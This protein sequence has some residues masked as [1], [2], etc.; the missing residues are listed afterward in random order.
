M[1][2]HTFERV[3][4]ENAAIAIELDVGAGATL[5]SLRN[6]LTARYYPIQ[7]RSAAKIVLSAAHRRMAI[8]YWRIRLSSPKRETDHL[9]EPGYIA[10]YFRPEVSDEDWYEVELTFGTSDNRVWGTPDCYEGYAWLRH[11]FELP[12]QAQGEVV[13]IVVGGYDQHD[14]HEY[15]IYVN[16]EFISSRKATA[17]WRQ[18]AVIELSPDEPAYAALRFGEHN[19]VA[20]QVCNLDRI[21]PD[22]LDDDRKRYLFN[23]S[24]ADQFVTIG[25]PYQVVEAFQLEGWAIEGNADDTIVRAILRSD[26]TGLVLTVIYEIRGDEPVLRKHIDVQNIGSMPQLLLDVVLLDCEIGGRTDLGGR[27]YPVYVNEEIFAAVEHPAG[28]NQGFG[29]AVRLWHCPGRTLAPGEKTPSKGLVIGVGHT[30]EGRRAFR[31]H[32]RRNGRRKP[33]P[34]AIYDVYGLYDYG[35]ATTWKEQFATEEKVLRALGWIAA[36]QHQSEKLFDYFVVDVGWQDHTSDLTRFNPEFWPEGPGRVV[37]KVNALGMKFGLWF[38]GTS[39]AWSCGA[40]PAVLPSSVPRPRKVLPEQP[41]SVA[42]EPPAKRFDLD[43]Q[44]C[45]AS[46]PFRTILRNAI[47]YHIRANSLRL[48]KLDNS[49]YVC[50]ND[51]HHHLPG[52]YSTEAMMDEIISLAEMAREECPDLFLMWYWGHSSP[53]W[54]LHGDTI[55]ECGLSIEA[56]NPSAFPSLVLRDSVTASMDEGAW[57]A[58]QIPSIAKDSLGIWLGQVQWANYM[59]RDGWR[60]AWMADLGRGNLLAQLWGDVFLFDDDDA[61]FL[62][63][64]LAWYRENS[65]ILGDPTHILGNPWNG[66]PYGTLHTGSDRAFIFAYNPTQEHRRVRLSLRAV[67]G[68]K[69]LLET[70]GVTR[71]YPDRASFTRRGGYSSTDT[72]EWWLRPFEIAV[73]RLGHDSGGIT[74]CPQ[75]DPL[76]PPSNPSRPISSTLARADAG[77]EGQLYMGW[78]EVPGVNEP[79]TA[80]LILRFWSHASPWTDE[81]LV[82]LLQFA[83]TQQGRELPISIVPSS[84]VWKSS[85]WIVMKVDLT[86]GH[87]NSRVEVGLQANLPPDVEVTYETWL[88]PQWWIE[89]GLVS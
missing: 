63:E 32:L 28:I 1:T 23:S 5:H 78:I 67:L 15:W 54:A 88:I 77:E 85:N 65:S 47:R 4:L 61:R 21:R 12:A 9:Q 64:T 53:F 70:C 89:P 57:L 8:P 24:L 87:S 18:P 22:M 37:D 82:E 42:E 43:P 66:E 72:L 40:N 71:L 69:L 73:L 17:Y 62:R 56:A 48:L 26:Q 27:G 79:S 34:H 80:A 81:Q 50:Q 86:P 31:D 11:S 39:A 3:T 33:V 55:A 52:K 83:V 84:R 30:G 60:N 68:H 75:I 41:F 76:Q 36:T 49:H 29:S 19:L 58:D 7:E 16:G 44:L 20:L 25:R 35:L 14:W 38:A 74:A 2:S 51:S 6:K 13:S 45:P 46:E 10:G 59:G